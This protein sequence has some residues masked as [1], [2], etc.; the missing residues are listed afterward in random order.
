MVITVEQ[1][2]EALLRSGYLLESRIEGVFRRRGY[3]VEAN[4]VYPDPNT[5][6]SREIDVFALGA[7]KAG[8]GETDFL[9][10]AF[11]VECVNNPE[12]VVLITKE[13]LV[14]F[15]HHEDIKVSGL[16][17]KFP[18][19]TAPQEWIRLSD[20]LNVEKWHHYCRGRVATQYCSFQKKKQTQDW[21]A[22]HDDAHFDSFRKLCSAVN[23]SVADHFKRW[24]FGGHES[25]N[26]QL[27]YPVL[28]VQGD[29]FEARPT[30]G[31]LSLRR[32]SHLAFRRSEFVGGEERDYQIDV[33]QE[34]YLPRFIHVV[35]RESK[36]MAK[37][38]RRRHREVRKA[39][40]KIVRQARR[41]KSPERIRAALDF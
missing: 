19:K 26:I 29:L 7:T 1:A 35:E 41:F 25:L 15:L 2:K 32:R 34:R 37:L 5:G 11:L 16:P 30:K 17:V 12:P 40:N 33:I 18:L 23:H 22:W 31:T 3:Y 6:T 9:F 10:S 8:P 36:K 14:A 39:I 13:P 27:Y 4:S 24:S 38:L 20:Y 28:I 21:M